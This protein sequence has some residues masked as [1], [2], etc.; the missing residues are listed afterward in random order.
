MRINSE[1]Y[2]GNILKKESVSGQ[3][4]NKKKSSM[5]RGEKVL[6]WFTFAFK[7]R[8]LSCICQTKFLHNITVD[9]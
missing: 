5:G 9:T 6:F 7:K 3:K 8:A 4:E 1:F 2:W